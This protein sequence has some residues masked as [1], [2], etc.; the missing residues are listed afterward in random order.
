MS[1]PALIRVVVVEPL[2]SGNIGSICRAMANTGLSDLVLVAPRVVDGWA[3]GERMACHAGAILRA[4]RECGTLPEAVA[5][6]VAV[7]GTTARLGLYRQ[8]VRTPREVAPELLRVASAGG[9]AAWV[10]GREDKGLS[11]EEV[12]CCTHLVRIPVAPGY[13]SL[14]VA[15]AAMICAYETFVARG[16]YEAPREKADLAPAAQREH[17]LRMWRRMLLGIGF[18]LPDKA[19]HM[20]QAFQRIFSRGA[21]TSDDV[22]ILMGVA[23]QAEWAAG[24]RR[25]G[26]GTVPGTAE[27]PEGSRSSHAGRSPSSDRRRSSPQAGG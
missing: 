3:D 14:N 13:V 21:W 9:R 1:D 2:Y 11:N 15:Q 24:S 6:C 17:L 10:F 5:D 7:A 8:H 20:M 22:H 12:A 27:R 18:M 26:A 16:T 4:R 23:R 25:E 19:D